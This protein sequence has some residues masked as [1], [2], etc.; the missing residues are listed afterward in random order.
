[1]GPDERPALEDRH[2]TSLTRE[3]NQEVFQD[4]LGLQRKSNNLSY[5]Y[6]LVVGGMYLLETPLVY[7][8]LKNIQEPSMSRSLIL[9][10]LDNLL[11][12]P[13]QLAHA[14]CSLFERPP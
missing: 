9:L 8:S 12:P 14:F 1:M 3:V 4:S 2:V 7:G 10:R 5:G 13:E 11:L 6:S